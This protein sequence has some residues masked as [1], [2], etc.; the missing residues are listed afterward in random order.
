MITLISSTNRKNSLT[1]R[2]TKYYQDI[3]K[4]KGCESKILDLADLPVDFL[5]TALYHEA[6]KNEEFNKFRAIIEA[7]EKFVFVVPEYN[8]SFPGVLKSFIDGMKYPYSFKNKKAALVG[9]S[10]GMMGGT[11]ALSH[12]TDIFNYLGMEILALKVKLAGLDKQM[13]EDKIVNKLYNELIDQQAD[14]LIK[15]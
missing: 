13:I 8:A 15:W 7:S 6:G 4:S 3:L 11:L 10:A 1:L 9:L 14:Q 5:F 2:V 12:L